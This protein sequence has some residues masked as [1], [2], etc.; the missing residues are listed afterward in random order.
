[1]IAISQI[2]WIILTVETDA[3]YR[4][5]YHHKKGERKCIAMCIHVLVSCGCIQHN[6][7]QIATSVP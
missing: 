4:S 6:I 7:V 3:I 1:M 5:M 2:Q